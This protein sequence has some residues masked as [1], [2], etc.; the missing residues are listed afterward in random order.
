ML[1]AHVVSFCGL[2]WPKHNPLGE[3][4]PHSPL[5]TRRP[6]LVRTGVDLIELVSLKLLLTKLRCGNAVTSAH[7]GQALA[8]G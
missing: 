1:P 7:A 8:K 5:D 6:K 2:W 3:I 4:S